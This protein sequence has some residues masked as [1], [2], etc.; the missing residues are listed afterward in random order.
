LLQ[1]WRQALLGTVAHVEAFIDFSEDENIEEDTFQGAVRKVKAD[2]RVVDGNGLTLGDVQV[3]ALRDT[4]AEHLSD[5][6]GGERLRNGVR[7]V[8]TGNPNVGKSI[9]RVGDDPLLAASSLLGAC[10]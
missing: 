4:M 5:N 6:R 10:M 1:G 3:E 8:L 7:V 9:A 2:S